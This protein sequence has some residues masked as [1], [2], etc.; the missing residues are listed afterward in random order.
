M[1][2]YQKKFA[3]C[4]RTSRTDEKV[5]VLGRLSG[6]TGGVRSVAFSPDGATIAAGS[7]DRSVRIWDAETR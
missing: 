7:N 3:R 1:V 6:H 4:P 2:F 5:D